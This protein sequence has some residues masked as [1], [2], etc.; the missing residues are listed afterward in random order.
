[1]ARVETKDQLIKQIE[2]GQQKLEKLL[3]TLSD[4]QMTQPGVCGAWSIKDMLAHIIEWHYLFLGWYEG[5]KRGEAVKTPTD[6]L[7][8]GQI[9]ILNQRFYE[10]HRARPLAEI[11]AEFKATCQKLYET[12]LEIPEEHLFA[13]P[14]PYAWLR[15]GVLISYIRPC[16]SG[17]YHWA[18]DLIRNWLKAQA[19]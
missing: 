19:G 13:K 3:A 9:D 11:R 6:D 8:W 15:T 12:A 2:T 14:A 17:H 1:M 16:T 18:S 10:K 4:E 7:N 5:G